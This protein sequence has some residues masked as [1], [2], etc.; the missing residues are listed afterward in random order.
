M[1]GFV[2]W[3]PFCT[4]I[5]YYKRWPSDKAN[6]TYILTVMYTRIIKNCEFKKGVGIDDRNKK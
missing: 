3:P 5:V 1:I 2:T 6:H 4:S